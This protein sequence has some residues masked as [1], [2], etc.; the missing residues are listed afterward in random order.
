MQREG[1]TRGLGVGLSGGV[2]AAIDGTGD[3]CS[4]HSR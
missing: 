3:A 4:E 1:E 2:E